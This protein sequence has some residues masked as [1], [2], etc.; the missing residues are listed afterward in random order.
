MKPVNTAIGLDIGTDTIKLVELKNE[1][2]AIRVI[3]MDSARIARNSESAL[4]DAQVIKRTIANL[5]AQNK[6]K[7]KN[8]VLGINGQS[9]FIKF[10][11]ILPVSRDKLAKTIQYETQ[12]QIPFSLDEVEYDTHLFEQPEKKPKMY[13]ALLV[14]IK[15]DRLDAKKLLLKDSG[16]GPSCIDVSTLSVYNCMRFN[17]EHDES[18]L[19]VILELG[20]RSTDLSIVKGRDFWMRS[21][22]FGADNITA[23]FKKRFSVDFSEAEKLKQKIDLSNPQT[24]DVIDSVLE[25]LQAEISRSIEYYYFQKKQSAQTEAHVDEMLITGGASQLPGLDKF[26][27]NKFSCPVRTLDPFKTL[28]VDS[29]LQSKVSPQSK[30]LYSQAVGLA[31]RGLGKTEININLLREQIMLQRF[32]RRRALYTAG[33]VALSVLILIAASTLMRQD[34]LQKDLHLKRLKDL[35]EKFSSYQPQL[36]ELQRKHTLISQEIELLSNLAM[37]RLI[38]L[39]VL[40]EIQKMLPNELWITDMT[41]SFSLDSSWERVETKLNLQGKAASYDDVNDLVAKL[42]SSVL[43]AEVKPLSSSFIEE[44][45]GA[46]EK[47]EVVKFAITMKVVPQDYRK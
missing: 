47:T 9:V 1:G 40:S 20:A 5:L 39:D 31:L 18:K 37:N 45:A 15:K 10:L 14:A 46:Q 34:Y 6:I 33:S 30:A 2:Q 41:G 28:L 44:K 24:K 23:A 4:E 38:W 25:D 7:A 42:K 27:E 19:T 13:R 16:V 21:F 26:L 17:R 22:A 11:E 8:V 43:F 29:H 12:Q 36:D 35:L 32:T 3:N